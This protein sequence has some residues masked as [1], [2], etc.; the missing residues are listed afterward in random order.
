[1]PCFLIYETG[2]KVLFPKITVSIKLNILKAPRIV[3]GIVSTQPRVTV[4]MS[5]YI[6]ANG[7]SVI[8][9]VTNMFR[10][11][12]GFEPRSCWFTHSLVHYPL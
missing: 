1:M 11:E 9:K 3:L 2:K 10:I 6:G 12:L 4:I 8:P 5:F 7:Q